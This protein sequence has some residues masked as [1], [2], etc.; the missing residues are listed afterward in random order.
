MFVKET[1][2][3]SI[4]LVEE[5][6][7]S[8]LVLDEMSSRNQ[9]WKLWTRCL[10]LLKSA[11]CRKGEM[12]TEKYD[13]ASLYR[14][15]EL[16]PREKVKIIL[17]EEF[18]KLGKIL[19]EQIL[20]DP[21]DKGLDLLKMIRVVHVW[22]VSNSLMDF[23][24][25]KSVD[26]SLKFADRSYVFFF[27]Q[28]WSPMSIVLG[29]RE[30][31]CLVSRP[32]WIYPFRKWKVARKTVKFFETV[33]TCLDRLGSKKDDVRFIIQLGRAEKGLLIWKII[34]WKVPKN[35]TLTTWLLEEKQQ[36]TEQ[37]RIAA[38]EEA[39]I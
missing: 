37:I 19:R 13:P 2:K 33:R 28:N 5:L 34:I 18:P 3:C 22:R 23:T 39:R 11:R 20:K 35:H 36:L 6:F 16:D 30:K 21:I 31:Y 25:L 26:Y 27:D 10:Q 1:N 4:T 14:S 38:L 15:E 17:D 7:E 12:K 32:S 9:T 8:S 29:E 24:P